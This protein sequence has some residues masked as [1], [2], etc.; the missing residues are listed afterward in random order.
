MS[1]E[2]NYLWVI[3]RQG[4]E[5]GV[6]AQCV[7]CLFIIIKSSV[8]SSVTLSWDP[9]ETEKKAQNTT[10][11]RK[12]REKK[13]CETII[14]TGC[15]QSKP[16]KVRLKAEVACEGSPASPQGLHAFSIHGFNQP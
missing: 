4:E 8:A 11:K 7:K 12:T 16:K 2:M 13:Q 10:K 6:V 3:R 1:L 14:A 9:E 5:T 15:V